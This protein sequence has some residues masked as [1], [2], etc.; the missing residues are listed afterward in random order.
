M[1]LT[2]WTPPE[3]GILRQPPRHPSIIS[4]IEEA[5]EETTRWN[6][7]CDFC[8]QI[9]ADITPELGVDGKLRKFV[10]IWMGSVLRFHEDRL[11]RYGPNASFNRRIIQACIRSGFA[12]SDLGAAEAWLKAKGDSVKA[13][14]EADNLPLTSRPGIAGLDGLVASVQHLTSVVFS[15]GI[16]EFVSLPGCVPH[17]F[18]IFEALLC[19]KSW[20]IWG[21]GSMWSLLK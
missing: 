19:R 17:H 12:S 2:G 16:S 13:R 4:L 6:V 14:F 7:L 5:P 3:H 8:F 20:I 9:E 21:R 11:L 1:G 15:Q 10:Y 18:L